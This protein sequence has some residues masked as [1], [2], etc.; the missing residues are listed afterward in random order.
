MYQVP[1]KVGDVTYCLF[2]KVLG[3][4]DRRSRPEDRLSTSPSSS[5]RR[6]ATLCGRHIPTLS[7]IKF[8]ICSEGAEEE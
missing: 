5:S 8:K 1:G 4:G 6:P 3:A 2:N 7:E